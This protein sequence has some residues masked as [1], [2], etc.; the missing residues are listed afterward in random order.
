MSLNYINWMIATSA[1]KNPN[2][3]LLPFELSDQIGSEV[4]IWTKLLVILTIFAMGFNFGMY[5]YI[6]RCFP[7]SATYQIQKIDSLVTSVSLTGM[8]T[9]LLSMISETPNG[10][11]CTFGTGAVLVAVAQPILSCLF[12]AY[13]G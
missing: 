8:L 4:L 3:T 1:L 12:L 10:Y 5:V 6:G 13:A 7:Q 9:S 2:Y 11:V